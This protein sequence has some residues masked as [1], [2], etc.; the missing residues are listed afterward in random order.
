[1]Y[2]GFIFTANSSVKIQQRPSERSPAP[3]CWHGLHKPCSR[4]SIPCFHLPMS[5]RE[6]RQTAPQTKVD[7]LLD[8]FPLPPKKAIWCFVYRESC[9]GEPASLP[10]QQPA[11]GSQI[12][13]Q[14]SQ[15]TPGAKKWETFGV[16]WHCPCGE[17]CPQVQRE[18]RGDS[19]RSLLPHTRNRARVAVGHQQQHPTAPICGTG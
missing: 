5:H 11:L 9:H 2:H 3:W 1:M 16:E 19:W 6:Q 12:P 13:A 14:K 17:H 15:K 7:F 18:P 10:A 8:S 4:A